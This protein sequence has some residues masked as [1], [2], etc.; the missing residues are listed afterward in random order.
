MQWYV[1]F[2]ILQIWLIHKLC[3]N[4]NQIINFLF[5]VFFDIVVKYISENYVRPDAGI[6]RNITLI[7]YKPVILSLTKQLFKSNKFV[8]DENLNVMLT[9]IIIIIFFFLSFGENYVS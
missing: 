7:I 2:A 3:H 9:N 6:P 8:M 4:M 5:S 1:S